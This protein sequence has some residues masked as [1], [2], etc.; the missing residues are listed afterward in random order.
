MKKQTSGIKLE[1][2]QVI[3]DINYGLDWVSNY[4]DFPDKYQ[5]NLSKYQ[6]VPVK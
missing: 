5:D 1:K 2:D 3:K 6:G 4:Q